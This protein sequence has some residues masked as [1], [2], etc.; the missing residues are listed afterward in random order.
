[1]VGCICS[2]NSLGNLQSRDQ[3]GALA[4]I[5]VSGHQHWWLAGGYDLEIGHF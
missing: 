3:A 1:M 2:L 4:I 5:E